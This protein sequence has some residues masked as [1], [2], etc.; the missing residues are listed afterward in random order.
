MPSVREVAIANG[1]NPNTVQRAFSLLVDEGY[2]TSVPK[3]GF[4]VSKMDNNR[5]TVL[6]DSLNKLMQ[7]GYTKTEIIN[8]LVNMGDK[9]ND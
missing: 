2:L 9:E 5:E 6:M 3:K 4:F 7:E 1:V 8:A